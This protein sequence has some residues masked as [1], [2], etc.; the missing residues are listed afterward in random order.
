[1]SRIPRG[2]RPRS[3]LQA[4][5]TCSLL[6]WPR[7]H[8]ELFDVFAPAMLFWQL[9]SSNGQMSRYKCLTKYLIFLQPQAFCDALYAPNSFSAGA[10]PGTPLGE[11]TTLPRPPSRLGRG[12]PPPHFPPLY[13][14]YER[15]LDLGVPNFISWKLATLLPGAKV[16][17]NFRSWERKFHLWNFRSRERKFPGAKVP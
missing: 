11:L 17:W 14:L 7:N 5:Q 4:L 1:M 6:Y 16:P 13:E 9:M 12:I 2:H 3:Q 8:L 15:R 10:L